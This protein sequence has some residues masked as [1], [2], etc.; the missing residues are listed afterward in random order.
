MVNHN[1]I[2]VIGVDQDD[3]E[4]IVHACKGAEIPNEVIKL[5]DGKQGINY[6]ETHEEKPFIILTDVYM[7]GLSGIEFRK[8]IEANPELRSK[9][10]PFIFLSEALLPAKVTEVYSMSVQGLFDKPQTIIDLQRMMRL[11]YDYWQLCRHPDQT[12]SSHRR[13]V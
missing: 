8:Q 10:V 11:I 13:E 1:P 4:M 5:A 12:D 6:L 7:S 9:S 2:L 3:F